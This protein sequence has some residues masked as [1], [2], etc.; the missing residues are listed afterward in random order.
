[1][2]RPRYKISQILRWVN[3]SGGVVAV[4]VFGIK[5]AWYDLLVVS[6]PNGEIFHRLISDLDKFDNV[7]PFLE[8][9]KIWKELNET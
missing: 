4:K 3:P 9:N 5:G 7:T 2:N 8:P 6:E 1:M